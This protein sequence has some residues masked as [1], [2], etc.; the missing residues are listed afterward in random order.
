MRW[1]PEDRRRFCGSVCWS[2]LL[3][4]VCWWR[5]MADGRW[6]PAPARWVGG[7]RYT[8]TRR[9]WRRRL[10]A[11]LEQQRLLLR[12][13]LHRARAA[14]WRG[15][16]GGAAVTRRKRDERLL[17]A[18]ASLLSSF[19]TSEAEDDDGAHPGGDEDGDCED[20]LFSALQQ[21]V[22]SRPQ[23]VL[24]ALQDL[25]QQFA[26]G[27]GRGKGFNPPGS[28]PYEKGWGRKGKGKGK[29][30]VTG[31]GS[32]T[33]GKG[34]K[35]GADANGWQIVA[36]KRK[37]L[38]S[39][40]VADSPP[41]GR[42]HWG[43]SL[44]SLPD[45]LVKP[46]PADWG[47]SEVLCTMGAL[48]KHEGLS[49]L[50]GHEQAK[51]TALINQPRTREGWVEAVKAMA[52][53][54]TPMKGCTA[55]MTGGR[56]VH[57]TVCYVKFGEGAPA[58]KEKLALPSRPCT[59]AKTCVLRFICEHARRWL[60]ELSPQLAT[61]V[62]D[63]WGWELQA[64]G[65]GHHTVVKGVFRV[66][67]DIAVSVM[68]HSGRQAHK[69]RWFVEK[70]PSAILP[71]PFDG[72]VAVQWQD[73]GASESDDGYAA[74]VAKLASA[75]GVARGIRQLGVRRPATPEDSAE[76]LKKPRRWVVKNVPR[77]YD[78]QDVEK[79]L[80]DLG[81]QDIDIRDK[82]RHRARNGWSFTAVKLD[83]CDLIEA[84][85]EAG[86][87]ITAELQKRK[88]P[89]AREA[90][91]LLPGEARTSFH[92]GQRTSRQEGSRDAAPKPEQMD[93]D[94][95]KAGSAKRDGPASADS[96]A[97][98]KRAKVGPPDG[99]E[100]QFNAGGGNCLFW[101]VSQALEAEGKSRS[102]AHVRATC[103]AHMRR[104]MST[105]RSYW[106]GKEPSGQ[107]KKLES[108]SFE[109]YVNMLSKDGA[110]AGY[111]ELEALAITM[112]RPILVVSPSCAGAYDFHIFNPDGAGKQINL[113][114]RDKHYQCL[115]NV[116]GLD[117]SDMAR[118]LDKWCHDQ[119]KGPKRAPLPA[120]VWQADV[121]EHGDVESHPGPGQPCPKD[122]VFLW[123]NTGSTVG[124]YRFLEHLQLLP[125]AQRPHVFGLG[126]TRLLPNDK[127]NVS[128]RLHHLGYRCWQFGEAPR[129]S[130]RN[131]QY[132][133]GGLCIAVKN[134]IRAAVEEH[135]IDEGGEAA[136]VDMRSSKLAFAW[137]RPHADHEAV[138]ATLSEWMYTATAMA[139]PFLLIAD[140][141]EEPG[142]LH[143]VEAGAELL[144]VSNSEGLVPSRFSEDARCID[145]AI[146]NAAGNQ[147]QPH[148]WEA[149]LSDHKVF[150]IK[151]HW[152]LQHG[153]NQR[154]VPTPNLA[155]PEG[156]DTNS[157]REAVEK[158][159]LNQAVSWALS[160]DANP[161]E[162]WQALSSLA[163]AATI[164]AAAH[165]GHE[166]CTLGCR[167]KGSMPVIDHHGNKAGPAKAESIRAQKLDCFIGRL[168]E[169]QRQEAQGTVDELLRARTA[170]SWPHDISRALPLQQ[171][172][173]AAEDMRSNVARDGR[174]RALA[175]WR[176]RIRQGGRKC[177]EWLKQ[178]RML[179][180]AAVTHDGGISTSHGESLAL[181]IQYWNRVWRRQTSC[182]ELNR[183]QSEGSSATPRCFDQNP[184]FDAHELLSQARRGTH[185]SAGPDGW[186]SEEVSHLP[187]YYWVLMAGML[188]K[189]MRQGRFPTVWRHCRM[190]M[191]PKDEF[192]VLS[193][194]VPVSKL[195]PIAVFPVHYR[196]L[197]SCMAKRASTQQWLQHRTP[198]W[199][200]GALRG[201]SAPD[202][203]T[204]S[205]RILMPSL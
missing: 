181:I 149:R 157:W 153:R 18:L 68:Q 150:Y 2:G 3:L 128:T 146:S 98:T 152:G 70:T 48:E 182:P 165:F 81:F 80:S 41:P 95:S 27:K 166:V 92:S 28:P 130:A 100:A 124:T 201:R 161:D 197:S 75:M 123:L 132:Q 44:D 26:Q 84:L 131:V 93:V 187:P 139:E 205:T 196:L 36:P 59:K 160:G 151:G 54:K 37:V 156:V 94:P 112:D 180:P 29:E 57:H 89:G 172:R 25:V 126:E 69:Q 73:Q 97:A 17:S 32:F 168:C 188:N 14:S 119:G 122:S 52:P 20:S 199:M 202:L 38:W 33:G 154:M 87:L 147:L 159:F 192:D 143:F 99:Y 5:W 12:G 65:A 109:D 148:Y 46:R 23:N 176:D 71:A 167:P 200:H 21:L 62:Q 116:K 198:P 22:A 191:I 118:R 171:A 58:P 179:L 117:V 64:G 42:K 66:H 72:R 145:Y 61:R 111:T 7:R 170:A 53:Q 173:K 136:L 177:T 155:K 78:F 47:C 96:A 30:D 11:R 193:G 56:V 194:P 19:D 43:N 85:D 140:F 138:D 189:W 8:C 13:R 35:R 82:F 31:T 74:R 125:V 184:S 79:L 104:H 91:T 134:T 144:A 114:F 195:R 77:D 10:Q 83:R 49:Y 204:R 190:I 107:D 90:P 6:P 120:S 106:D 45:A 105:C 67:E 1:R 39:E 158:E 34:G 174:N 16:G 60:T 15:G 203:R 121:K 175:K 183:L 129:T 63:S 137:R 186:S 103:V 115:K 40:V 162:D 24:R 127:A 50:I 185:G 110:W 164:K 135:I 163:S 113:W 86:E 55:F 51:V 9:G 88:H 108:G 101:S 178:R 102:H 4:V 76:Q 141:N 169:L 133:A 142:D